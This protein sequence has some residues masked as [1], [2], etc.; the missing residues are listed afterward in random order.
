MAKL[1]FFGG[2]G[3]GGGRGLRALPFREGHIIL[4]YFC[5]GTG[6]ECVRVGGGGGHPPAPHSHAPELKWI[7]LCIVYVNF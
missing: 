3:G 6:N 7:V 4:T 1:G 2:G 5:G